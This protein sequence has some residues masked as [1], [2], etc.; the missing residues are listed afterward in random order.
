MKYIEYLNGLIKDEVL[1]TDNCVL[2]GQ[3]IDA[4]SCLGGLTKNIKVNENSR[5]FNSTN[6]EN[7]LVGFGFGLMMNGAA[8]VFFMKQMDFLLLGIDQLVNTF[9]IIRSVK[10]K[11]PNGSFTIVATVMDCGY[12]GPQSSFNNFY[13]ICSIARIQ[14]L[15]ITNKTDADYIFS[16]HFLQAGFRIIALSQRLS[17]DDIIETMT[18]I[19]TISNGEIFQY[20]EGKDVTVVSF[21]FSFPQSVKFIKFLEANGI[22]ASHF[23]VNGVT[24]SNW[25]TIIKDVASTKKI[26]VIDD[27]KSLNTSIDN[28]LAQICGMKINNK[29]VL[30]RKLNADW[31]YPIDDIFEIDEKKVLNQ[32]TY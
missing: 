23:N 8:G 5:I 10:D 18:P 1:K 19:K 3:N 24:T 17:K 29:I 22:Q 16:Q 2:F 26:V 21:N 27:S 25:E 6:A 15:T 14:G 12:D 7:S 30:N 4:G 28:L 11:Y 13:D 9:N 31:L 32:L 20:R